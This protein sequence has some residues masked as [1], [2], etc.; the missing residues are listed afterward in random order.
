[1]R[2]ERGREN[3]WKEQMDDSGKE[4]EEEKRT[5]KR[6]R[7]RRKWE[8]RRDVLMVNHTTEDCANSFGRK[9]LSEVVL[10]DSYLECVTPGTHC[11]RC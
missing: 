10:I 7:E 3:R 1:M 11:H 2:D 9:G 4:D 6:G 8:E 5:R